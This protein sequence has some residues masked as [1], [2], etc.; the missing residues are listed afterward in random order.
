[1]FS[2]LITR[3][4]T[5][6]TFRTARGKLDPNMLC[7]ARQSPR[8]HTPHAALLGLDW[9]IPGLSGIPGDSTC[10]A[11]CLCDRENSC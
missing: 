11:F 9:K 1:M 7:R 10:E 3:L 2:S 5:L 8:P 4:N 6:F